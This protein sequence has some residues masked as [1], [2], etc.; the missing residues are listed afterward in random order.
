VAGALVVGGATTGTTLALWVDRTAVS[1]G[2]LRS[3]SIALVVNGSTSATF[4]DISDLALSTG[5]SPGA[6]RS[7]TATLSNAG[8]GKN[9]RMNIQLDDVTTTSDALNTGLEIAVQGAADTTDC[10]TPATSG[11]EDLSATNAHLLTPV[12]IAPG[13]TWVMCVSVR[14][15]GGTGT[16]LQNRSGQLTFA[17]RGAQVRL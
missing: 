8:T 15:K 2:Q 17:F 14:S 6:A 11:Y 4:A 16:G 13:G 10:P 1:E 5:S 9:M 3:G 7:F 12:S